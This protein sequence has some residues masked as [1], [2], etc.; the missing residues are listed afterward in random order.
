MEYAISKSKGFEEFVSP[1]ILLPNFALK[2]LESEIISDR[3]KRVIVKRSQEFLDKSS[4]KAQHKLSIE[5][6][7]LEVQL[8]LEVINTMASIKVGPSNVLPF[9]TPLLS[10]LELGQLAVVLNGFGGVFAQMSSHSGKRPRLTKGRHIEALVNRLKELGVV[11]SVE[12]KG[13]EIRVNMRR[14]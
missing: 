10:D 9:L 14:P 11:S 12:D 1:E 4:W 13:S 7:R 6:E 5:A 3:V 2:V 8:P